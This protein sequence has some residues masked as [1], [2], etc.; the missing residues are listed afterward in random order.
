[1]TAAALKKR[2]EDAEVIGW[3]A[4]DMSVLNAGQF[5]PP[6]MPSAL[7][8]DLWPLLEAT[9]EGCCAPVDYVGISLLVSAASAIGGSRRVAPWGQSQWNE[10]AILWGG[11]IGDPS[12]NKSPA[13][14]KITHHLVEI[15]RDL[16]SDFNKV[17]QDYET[18][19]ATAKLTRAKW[20]TE[21]KEA[22]GENRAS[23]P[24]PETAVEPDEPSPPRQVTNDVTME[25]L[26]DVLAS[27]PRGVLQFSDELA[28]WLASHDAYKSNSRPFWL[29]AYDGSPFSVDRR[30]R[31]KVL[32]IPYAGTCVIGGIQPAK[33]SDLFSSGDDGLSARFL[34]VWPNRVQRG[35]PKDDAGGHAVG[36]M[37]RKLRQ[38]HLPRAEN[39]DPQPVILPFDSNA[40]S[41]LEKWEPINQAYADDLDP[42]VKG[43]VGKLPGKVARLAL[44]SEL[45]KWAK[46]GGSE[47]RE[48]SAAS[49]AA[50][51]E[52]ADDYLKPMA[53]R[54]FGDAALP[55]EQRQAAQ[56]AKII[57][58]AR[59]EILNARDLKK[60]VYA[61]CPGSLKGN[62]AFDDAARVLEDAGW[63]RS[64]PPKPGVGGRPRKDYIVNPHVHGAP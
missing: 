35:R 24:R 39:G 18:D 13:I 55:I 7:F 17:L 3:D 42:I 57:L 44:V 46:S 33:L 52:F 25:A 59:V 10:P 5:P 9:A 15:E 28:G 47:P 32:H 40:Q 61:P 43:Y 21:V 36:V 37:L 16:Q 49:V 29:Q 62:E 22:V 1:M 30:N 48:V 34:W 50:A 23:P 56:L 64:I 38:L 2:I 4:P 19:V 27:N 8:G 54:V 20:E 63:I 51:L 60:G 53:H 58:K 26:C 12:V 6:P 45:I 11:L 31:K 14:K 41:L